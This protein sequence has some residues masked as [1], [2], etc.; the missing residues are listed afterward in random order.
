MNIKNN[1]KTVSNADYEELIKKTLIF[2]KNIEKSVVEGKVISVD[3]N[4][5]IIDVGLKSEGRIPI[6]EFVRT[7]Q[8]PEINVGDTVN[9]YIDRIDSKNGET[10][11]SREKA[12]KQTSWKKLQ[13]S[14]ETGKTVVGVPFSRVKGGLTV[15][16]EGV[17][18]FLPGSQIDSRPP[19][20][21]TKE[22]L[23]KPIDLVILKMDQLRGNIIVSR[24][25]IIDKELRSKRDKLLSSIKEGSI[26]KGN[27]KNITDYGAFVDLGG[28][29]GL[30]HIT[31]I[32]WRKINHPS[33]ILSLGNEINVKILKF[34]EEN[35]RLSLG[36]K[37]LSDDPWEKVDEEFDVD[38]KYTGKI[39]N[40]NDNGVSISLKENFEGFIQLQDLNWL[41]KPPPPSKLFQDDQTIEVKVLS[42]DHEK[43]RLNCGVKQLKINPW[44]NITTIYK[45]G[46]TIDAEIVNKVDYGIFV[47]IYEEIDGMV[48]ISDLSWNEDENASILNSLQKGNTIKV[49]ILEIDQQKERVS[50]SAK[51]LTSDPV[52]DYISKNPI[53][54]IVSGE[55]ID[56]NDKGIIV[57]LSKNINGFI[58]KSNLS[59]NKNEQKIDRFA[60]KEK[61]DSMIISYDEKLR[62]INLSV[63]D[64]EVHEEKEALSQYG[65][66]D[67]GASLGDILGEALDKKNSA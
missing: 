67:S 46:D 24:K 8:D 61:I 65:S 50:L 29:D 54:S 20:K 14:F 51:H 5:V 49:N 2:E 30:V 41:K 38:K 64:M 15:D 42:I 66:S 10:K 12:I 7:N 9:V 17:I 63:K 39:I 48:H 25:A 57:N 47:K 53:K 56:T 55:I 52:T 11:L 16:L 21:D 33:E 35:T 26:I 3:K 31:D 23:N 62:K 60:K 32:S 59:K 6:S 13:V 40:I 28:I 19:F 22:F 36:I 43:K 45:I 18:A 4:N 37:Q 1:T 34:D 27:I 44:E 58:K